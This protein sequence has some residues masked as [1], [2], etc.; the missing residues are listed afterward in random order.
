N[1]SN[2]LPTL[3]E[4]IGDTL[5]EK[6]K[7]LI[8]IFRVR[9]ETHRKKSTSHLP[10]IEPIARNAALLR[11]RPSNR[12]VLSTNPD[13]L[14]IPSDPDSSLSQIV[15]ELPDGFY[16]L[17]RFELPERL[18]ESCL[19]RMDPQK[20]FEFLRSHGSLL[21]LDTTV[22]IKS[23][24]RYDAPGDFQ[25]FLR[26]DL[27]QLNGFDEK[28]QKGWHVDSNLNK[29][30]LALF[31]EGKSLEDLLWGFHCNH[32]QQLS[33][34]HTKHATENS[35]E[36]FIKDP[37]PC[38]DQKNWGLEDVPLE[39]IVFQQNPPHVDSLLKILPPTATKKDF[40]LGDNL[41][42]AFD[43]SSSRIL[44]FLTDHLIYLPKT[45]SIA[46]FGWNKKMIEKLQSYL[47]ERGFQN[48]IC[49]AFEKKPP[50]FAEIAKNS[51]LLIFDFG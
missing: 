7:S 17:P 1:S 46:Y 26:K 49:N 42:N 16:G 11:S 4:A 27:F 38:P 34:Q 28:M 25:L 24:A 23:C 9:P 44:A 3:L 48:Q 33:L 15:A 2:D 39:E 50:S 18:W 6:A 20:N 13:M 45:A 12:W 21:N 43:Y 31:S 40:Y 41:Y 36:E 37:K 22:R 30:A 14:F 5:S 32:T 51:S 29:R 19:H 8:R 47:D 10:L 35:W